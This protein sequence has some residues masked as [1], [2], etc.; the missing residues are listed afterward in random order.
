[1]VVP[2][3]SDFLRESR[4]SLGPIQQLLECRNQQ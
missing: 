3:R 1:V 4:S 2:I